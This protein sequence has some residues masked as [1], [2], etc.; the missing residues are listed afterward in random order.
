MGEH[1]LKRA[2]EEC[3]QLNGRM[4]MAC[5]PGLTEREKVEAVVAIA[6]AHLVSAKDLLVLALGEKGAAMTM[7]MHA[8][9]LAGKVAG[10]AGDD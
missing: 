5:A 7:Y 9:D 4:G 8:D 1:I 2:L 3:A 10:V 6:T